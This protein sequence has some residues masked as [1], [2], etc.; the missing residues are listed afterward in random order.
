MNLI[1]RPLLVIYIIISAYL[2]SEIYIS[3]RKDY[4]IKIFLLSI[5]IRV[6]I[7][8]FLFNIIISFLNTRK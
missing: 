8:R 6:I 3:L 2:D 1:H 4:D 7:L 5:F